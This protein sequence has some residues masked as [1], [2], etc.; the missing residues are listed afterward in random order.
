LRTQNN[1][2]PCAQN[3]RLGGWFSAF[4]LICILGS[5]SQDKN[6]LP[7]EVERYLALCKR[8][9]ER[10]VREGTWPWMDSPNSDDVIESNDNSTDI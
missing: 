1:L 3:Q 5:M 6:E 9:Y 10:M 4:L 8:T 7:P 2:P